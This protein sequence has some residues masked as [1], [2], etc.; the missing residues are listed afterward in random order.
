M[1]CSRDCLGFIKNDIT[2]GLNSNS[3]NIL[4]IWCGFLG[5]LFIAPMQVVMEL[6]ACANDQFACENGVCV[7]AAAVCNG[8][9]DCGDRSDEKNCCEFGISHLKFSKYMYM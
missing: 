4:H 7:A 6:S 5:A 8:I 3:E 9:D 2:S 1:F